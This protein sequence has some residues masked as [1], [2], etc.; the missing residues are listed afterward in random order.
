MSDNDPKTLFRT[1]WY[2]PLQEVFLSHCLMR[3]D[4]ER[5]RR[6]GEDFYRSRVRETKRARWLRRV[7]NNFL[8][9]WLTPAERAYWQDPLVQVLFKLWQQH[10]GGWEN[11]LRPSAQDRTRFLQY[12]LDNYARAFHP[13]Y[14][15]VRENHK[16]LVFSL[17]MLRP[18]Q[19]VH[20]Y[21]S[22]SF[23]QR[24]LSS[25]IRQYIE[26]AAITGQYD[27]LLRRLPPYHTML[28]LPSAGQRTP[29][30]ARGIDFRPITVPLGLTYTVALHL[31]KTQ[32]RLKD[33]YI[34]IPVRYDEH[35][36][37]LKQA[38][39]RER[40]ES[41]RKL[42]S[43]A[44]HIGN[45]EV[46]ADGR[47][48]TRGKSAPE[49]YYGKRR[50]QYIQ[51][52]DYLK[53][54]KAIP[55]PHAESGIRIRFKLREPIV[56]LLEGLNRKRPLTLDE[57]IKAIQCLDLF[58]SQAGLP[59]AERDNLDALIEQVFDDFDASRLT[60]ETQEFLQNLERI[61]AEDP[62]Q[63]SAW[64]YVGQLAL[65]GR[66]PN[67]VPAICACLHNDIFELVFSL[68]PLLTGT[69]LHL[70]TEVRQE[71]SVMQ[72]FQNQTAEHTKM[73]TGTHSTL[74]LLDLLRENLEALLQGVFTRYLDIS[75]A[76]QQYNSEAVLA[77]LIVEACL[78]SRNPAHTKRPELL[79]HLQ[80][81]YVRHD[82]FVH[83]L[84]AKRDNKTP[85]AGEVLFRHGAE[86]L[87]QDADGILELIEKTRGRLFSRSQSNRLL[88]FIE[89][90]SV[91]V[92]TGSFVYSG[93]A[94]EREQSFLRHYQER[95]TKLAEIRHHHEIQHEKEI[96]Q[97][98]HQRQQM[99]DQESMRAAQIQDADLN[100]KAQQ[101]IAAKRA[102]TL[103]AEFD[104]AA[105]EA[106]NAGDF[107][108]Y[109]ALSLHKAHKAGGP[110]AV[111]QM[112]RDNPELF[113]LL[114]KEA[115]QNREV[116]KL[117]EQVFAHLIEH[118]DTALDSE[119]TVPV[120]AAL[121]GLDLSDVFGTA[122]YK[123]V[124]DV[125]A[126]AVGHGN[127]GVLI[128]HADSAGEGRQ[129]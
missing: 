128:Q 90:G 125:L 22:Y 23:E 37:A 60:L 49:E 87:R 34:E 115:Y 4:S 42:F 110:E 66:H 28:H 100:F 19:V 118:P 13:D 108:K 10:V 127:S 81:H 104:A 44:G 54:F 55:R 6:L 75:A 96:L 98:S 57:L 121:F 123:R 59:Y 78:D 17:A 41:L 2:K 119:T 24:P 103:F 43:D 7:I 1:R 93:T 53:L 40:E 70:D 32:T 107:H 45:I 35:E 92:L 12:M 71:P 5:L 48:Y 9:D 46:R 82:E 52:Q 76:T 124:N 29:Y 62:T 64:A 50:A 27:I 74:P 21:L 14:A 68:W 67:L 89:P 79:R 113:L 83:S 91:E 97:Q 117:K 106:L 114:D 30:D 72:L 120:M 15:Q 102:D 95:Q 31:P 105:G 80:E 36:E 112:L 126:G 38:E 94:L 16:N 84:Y 69:E 11:D 111:N 77:R 33:R 109:A 116:Q 25:L 56:A 18:N 47:V 88:C 85:F 129:A 122:A 8:W 3:E 101:V 73:P 86:R 63:Q 39:I 65:E 20:I 61:R 99:K 26:T 58:S 51:D